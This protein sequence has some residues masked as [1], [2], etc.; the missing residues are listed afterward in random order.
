MKARMTVCLLGTI[1]FLGP[2]TRAL[3]DHP[4]VGA[5]DPALGIGPGVDV[6]QPEPIVSGP[7]RVE[8]PLPTK[9]IRL[10]ADE[11]PLSTIRARAHFPAFD[12]DSFFVSLPPVAQ[13][14]VS[15]ADVLA[16]VIAPVLNAIGFK[17][18]VGALA[19]PPPSGVKQPVAS[20][21]RLAQAVEYEYA[22]HPKLLRPRTRKMID[23][24][25]GKIPSDKEID[26]ALETG[27]GMDFAQFVAGI[28]RVE[29]QYPFQQIDAGVPIE[30]A[31]IVASR[32]EGQAITSV[33]GALLNEYV[34][35]NEPKL[36]AEGT[37]L[38]AITALGRVRGVE[39]VTSDRPEEGPFLVLL[40][41]G[42]DAAGRARL[43]Y[44]YRMILR[45]VFL[46]QEG[47]FVLWIDAQTGGI[48][49]LE[50]L[51]NEVVASGVVYNRDPGVGTNPSSF[52]VDPS[53]GGQYTLQLPGVL[54][55]VD[56]QGDGYNS[57][58]VSI[59][60]NTNGS[61]PTF[62][63]F[64]HA[65]INE[66]AQAL[67]GSGPNKA[68]QQVNVFATIHR[69]RETVL[70]QGIFE[71]FPASPWAPR[72][73]VL[74]FNADA[75]MK[76]GAR[77]G[78]FDPACPDYY[79]GTNGPRDSRNYM[80]FAHDNTVIGHEVAHSITPR[81]TIARPPDWCGNPPCSIPFGWS[82]L[83][84]LADFWADHFESTNCTAGWV[85]KNLEG[86]DASLN[87]QDHREDSGL[88]RRHEVTLP[89][90]PAVPGDHFP[91]HRAGGNTCDYCDSQ[92]GAVALW[93]VRLGMRSKCRPSGLP[94]FGVRFQRALKNTGI[95]V[96]PPSYTDTGVY[97]QLY[98]LETR[99]ID[100]W[101][102]SGS[103]GGP[104]AFAHNGPHTTH[105]VTA[106]FA[107]AGL[108]LIPYQCL[109]G[110]ALSGDP[111]FC[112]TEENGGDAVIDIDDNDPTDDLDVN[113]IDHPEVDF[114]KLGSSAR[115]TIHVWT[116]PRYRLNGPAGYSTRNNPAPCNTK[117]RVE[118]SRDPTFPA[119]SALTIRSSPDWINVDVDP[120]TPASAECYGHWS[121]S[122]SEW[123][124]LQAGGHL[125]RI[126][127]RAWTRDAN[128][129]NERVSTR[130][131]NGLWTVPPPYA[132]L[133]IDG[134]SDY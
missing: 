115:P 68:F 26:R 50:P 11:K 3:A 18:G 114:L 19:A 117:F 108:F 60:D 55:R 22:N 44:A 123:T 24:F 33:W 16:K 97:Q 103:P 31:M 75:S 70:A 12:G 77:Q 101:A 49:K 129:A 7:P 100:Q 126:Y 13:P 131:G 6:P 67:C 106:G 61:S 45:G 125:S 112:P 10:S 110:D 64:D 53:S 92:I 66:S 91:E 93:Q 57:R 41:Y 87:C 133:T 29:I 78:Y 56:Y 23:V 38:S 120:T 82:R 43:R 84:D 48:L 124:T 118:V 47:R 74:N 72:V 109:D 88:P 86:V 46:G 128:D 14:D 113:G 94:Q 30:R 83:H 130:P 116:G 4:F 2:A 127:Y 98:D 59:L 5:Q 63:N 85:S 96:Y 73:E 69:Y 28:Q 122:D 132:V 99:L 8:V 105:K 35:V 95:F 15:A 58:D 32:W 89:F 119:D 79:D 90:N 111:S 62:A 37:V 81:L 17:R 34:I 102:T 9:R 80:N 42:T 104:P 27:Q 76:F 54:N 39:K 65:P 107:R 1:L 134:R 20:F 21:K 40:P 52:E 71:P 25:L 51:F 36:T 121:P